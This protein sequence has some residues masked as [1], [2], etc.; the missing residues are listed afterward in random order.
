MVERTGVIKLP[1]ISSNVLKEIDR[2]CHFSSINL[3]KEDDIF[4]LMAAA[5][6]FQ[7]ESIITDVKQSAYECIK[8]H[9]FDQFIAL[10][11]VLPN[12]QTTFDQVV[13]RIHHGDFIKSR[14]FLALP[15]QWVSY[16]LDFH[17]QNY[18][19]FDQEIELFDAVLNWIQ[20]NGAIKEDKLGLLSKIRYH[21]LSDYVHYYQPKIG[22]VL[23]D[24]QLSASFVQ[25]QLRTQPTQE[26]FSTFTSCKMLS[27]NLF[28][29]P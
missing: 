13:L 10:A 5:D 9:S 19:A 8:L 23:G 29:I 14:Q 7:I 1:L 20:V 12:R 28:S 15:F 26:Q 27:K 2:Y 4:D 11:Q 6:Y 22:E 25:Q 18:Q 3:E 21:A 17:N 16:F 24:D